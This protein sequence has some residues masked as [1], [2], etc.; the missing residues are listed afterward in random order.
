MPICFQISTAATQKKTKK[1]KKGNK[2]CWNKEKLK[3][4]AHLNAEK[5]AIIFGLLGKTY[6][7]SFYFI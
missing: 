5:L 4:M 3:Q 2:K 6:Y 1:K 7:I